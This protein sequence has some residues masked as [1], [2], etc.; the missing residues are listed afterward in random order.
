[1]N[2]DSILLSEA[3]TLLEKGGY[4]FGAHP[5]ESV[6]ERA[7]VLRDTLAE[8]SDPVDPIP[9][10]AGKVRE[11]VDDLYDLAGLNPPVWGGKR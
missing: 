8:A 9:L 7:D 1:M 10:P 4:D 3:Q 11:L 2:A 5:L 6:R